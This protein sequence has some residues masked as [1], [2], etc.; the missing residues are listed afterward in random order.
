MKQRLAKDAVERCMSS[1]FI[2]A[3]LDYSDFYQLINHYR[4]YKLLSIDIDGDCFDGI[5][6]EWYGALCD[7]GRGRK[8]R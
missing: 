2:L 5:S 6:R 8:H 1:R 7:T 4:W 3:I